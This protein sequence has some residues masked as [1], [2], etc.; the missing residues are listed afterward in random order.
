ML[1]IYLAEDVRDGDSK[2]GSDDG[3]SYAMR[4]TVQ[5]STSEV[6]HDVSPDYGQ[7]DESVETHEDDEDGVGRLELGP[8]ED[9]VDVVSHVVHAVHAENAEHQEEDCPHQDVAESASQPEHQQLL[10]VTGP[11]ADVR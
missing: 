8:Q 9:S 1:L 5:V 2:S 7:R 10:V 11:E 3:D 6:D 4:H